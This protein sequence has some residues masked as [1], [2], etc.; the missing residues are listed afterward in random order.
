MAV[1]SSWRSCSSPR[2][3]RRPLP[4]ST[5]STCSASAKAPISANRASLKA[6]SRPSAGPARCP[7][8][9]ALESVQDRPRHLLRQLQHCQ[10]RRL[11]RHLDDGSGKIASLEEHKLHGLRATRRALPR[12]RW[13]LRQ[14]SQEQH[15]G[16]RPKSGRV[17]TIRRSL[18]RWVF[19]S[20]PTGQSFCPRGVILRTSGRL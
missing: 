7:Q 19:T 12:P 17:H 5:P 20:W 3:S 11:F 9:S 2:R 15:A 14:P 1:R 10:R 6:S 16:H 18:C 8:V 13:P 4:T